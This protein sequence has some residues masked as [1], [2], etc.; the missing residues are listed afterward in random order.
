M[1]V[2]LDIEGRVLTAEREAGDPG[3]YGTAE[4]KGESAVLHAIKEELIAQ[5]HDVIKKRMYK[6]GHLVD[7]MKQYIRTRRY[8]ETPVATPGQ[9]CAHNDHWQIRGLNDDWNETGRATLRVE[10]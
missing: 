5:G 3:Y 6:D 7:D 9:F 1:K 2:T 10:V 8:M 4:A